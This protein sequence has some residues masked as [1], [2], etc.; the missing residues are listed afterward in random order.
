MTIHLFVNVTQNKLN[1]VNPMQY[2][3]SRALYHTAFDIIS[4]KARLAVFKHLI[5][6][7]NWNLT[8]TISTTYDDTIDKSNLYCYSEGAIV[9]YNYKNNKTHSV[10]IYYP[11]CYF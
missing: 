11:S 5:K 10:S 6:S 2:G 7:N 1:K 9:K 8:D 3:T 4:D